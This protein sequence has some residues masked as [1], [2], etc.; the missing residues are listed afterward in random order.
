MRE[1]VFEVRG[2]VCLAEY[3]HKHGNDYSVHTT[4]EGAQNWFREIVADWKADFI[5]EEDDPWYDSTIDELVESW[6]EVTGQT[7][8]FN[9]HELELQK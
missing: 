6:S 9:I 4:H 3:G 7:E 2:T 5:L 8:F 1:T